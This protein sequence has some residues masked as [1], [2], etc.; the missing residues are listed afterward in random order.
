MC[1]MRAGRD[2]KSRESTRINAYPFL[3]G[4]VSSNSKKPLG[5][6]PLYQNSEGS[7]KV[8]IDN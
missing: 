2:S 7:L 8:W 6:F 1:A 3:S 5:L 4:K